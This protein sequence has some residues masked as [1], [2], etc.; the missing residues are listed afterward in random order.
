M[1]DKALTHDS[2]TLHVSKMGQEGETGYANVLRR[3]AAHGRARCHLVPAVRA[4][5]G[6]MRK[7]RARNLSQLRQRRAGR[8]GAARTTSARA[9]ALRAQL[10]RARGRGAHNS[11]PRA[12]VMSA[13]HG[14]ARQATAAC[15]EQRS[16]RE[17]PG[18]AG[19]QGNAGWT[20][21]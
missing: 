3:H 16:E 1:L 6:R 15:E 10:A 11:P 8:T 5:L 12:D 4:S 7:A 17:T 2:D 21:R 9:R 14:D 13:A 20:R 18:H 19:A